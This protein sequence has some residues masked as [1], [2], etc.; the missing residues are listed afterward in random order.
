LIKNDW[1]VENWRDLHE[2]NNEILRRTKIRNNVMRWQGKT[3]ATSSYKPELLAMVHGLMIIP[4]TWNITWKTDSK[5]CIDTLH[6]VRGCKT[7]N[8]HFKEWELVD[9]LRRLINERSGN[10]EAEHQRAH[11]KEQ[12]MDAVGNATA[13]L[14][15]SDARWDEE[16]RN[17]TIPLSLNSCRFFLFEGNPEDMIEQQRLDKGTLKL[18]RATSLARNIERGGAPS[19]IHD[20]RKHLQKRHKLEDDRNWNGNSSQGNIKSKIS[21]TQQKVNQHRKEFKG[22]KVETLTNI[23]TEVHVLKQVRRVREDTWKDKC[24]YCHLIR[25]TQARLDSNHE[26]RCR[27]DQNGVETTIKETEKQVWDL[28][29]AKWNTDGGSAPNKEAEQILLQLKAIDTPGNTVITAGRVAAQEQPIDTLRR[30]ATNITSE[31][32]DEKFDAGKEAETLLK[33]VLESTRYSGRVKKEIAQGVWKKVVRITKANVQTNANSLNQNKHVTYLE[34]DKTL[35]RCKERKSYIEH[36]DRGNLQD[37]IKQMG[38][39]LDRDHT[40]WA[41]VMTEADEKSRIQMEKAGFALIARDRD[42]NHNIFFK[43]G[44]KGKIR[45][46]HEAT[47]QMELMSRWKKGRDGDKVIYETAFK[48]AILLD[49]HKHMTWQQ[50]KKAQIGEALLWMRDPQKSRGI[51]TDEDVRTIQDKL[52]VNVHKANKIASKAELAL[53]WTYIRDT[54]NKA[55]KVREAMS[56]IAKA[57]RTKE[58]KLRKSAEKTQREKKEKLRQRAQ[59]ARKRKNNGHGREKE[60]FIPD[61]GCGEGSLSKQEV[62]TIE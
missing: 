4:S 12:S 52:Q 34:Q 39:R 9:L 56:Q 1:F 61:C 54:E 7:T 43:T 57:Q 6:S 48:D 28:T 47:R 41:T 37:T 42:S 18:R 45:T 16:V 3:M 25:G 58:E 44:I 53:R 14:L 24:K 49:K 22:Q 46:P 27:E 2:N 60:T 13:D 30:I 51:A 38:T 36:S 5:A 10:F 40:A 32:K 21:N 35:R 26:A 11:T 31:R 19:P 62:H 29:R 15:A 55:K 20:M 33:R 50:M 59:Q 23:L 8:K 17:E